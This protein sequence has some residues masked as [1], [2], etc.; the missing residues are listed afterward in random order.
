MQIFLMFFCSQAWTWT[1]DPLAY[2]LLFCK[3][4]TNWDTWA[5]YFCKDMNNFSIMQIFFKFFAEVEN[6]D[7]PTHCLTGNCSASELHLHM[8]TITFIMCEW[9]RNHYPTFFPKA[10]FP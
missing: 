3:T 5:F 1:K 9:V 8:W 10:V 2:V 7:I 4:S 6:Y